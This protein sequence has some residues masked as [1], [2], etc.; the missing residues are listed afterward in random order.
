MLS[1]ATAQERG[2]ESSLGVNWGTGQLGQSVAEPGEGH[3][4]RRRE[5]V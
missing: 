5:H 3:S 4:G 1:Q 2:T